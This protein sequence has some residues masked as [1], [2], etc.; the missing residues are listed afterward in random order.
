MSR[1]LAVDPPVGAL[2]E[3]TLSPFTILFRNVV[4]P[5]VGPFAVFSGLGSS[6]LESIL[7]KSP[8]FLLRPVH[9]EKKCVI[10]EHFP[11]SF[12]WFATLFAELDEHHFPIR[13]EVDGRA[14]HVCPV[15]CPEQTSIMPLKFNG[16]WWFL[17]VFGGIWWYLIVFG[18]PWLIALS[19]HHSCHIN[20]GVKDALIRLRL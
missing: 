7:A 12:V 2:G 4:V 11:G 14:R 20:F 19:K 9:A 1:M 15:H 13:E 3:G 10:E 6:I 16:I 5:S 18:G 17:V 8:T